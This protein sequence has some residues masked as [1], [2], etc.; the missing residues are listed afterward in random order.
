MSSCRS[1][2]LLIAL[3]AAGCSCALSHTDDASIADGRVPDGSGG[4]AETSED[5]STPNDCVPAEELGGRIVGFWVED[6]SCGPA[7]QRICQAALTALA[8]GAVATCVEGLSVCTNADYCPPADPPFC[9]CRE[10]ACLGSE[11][12]TSPTVGGPQSCE[13]LCLRE[14]PTPRECASDPVALPPTFVPGTVECD[15]RTERLCRLWA[16]AVAPFGYA[17]ASCV[18]G[19]APVFCGMGDLCAMGDT[20]ERPRCDCGGSACDLEEVCVSDTPEGSP[21]CVPACLPSP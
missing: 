15:A 4:D 5:G 14:A 20:Q 8:P 19:T 9:S 18:G 21:R 12:C 13:P 17:H 7:Q 10:R 16:Q 6:R 1:S 2:A 11:I 3:I